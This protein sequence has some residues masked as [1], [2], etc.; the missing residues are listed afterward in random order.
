MFP[1]MWGST[2]LGFGGIGGAAMTSAYTVIVFGC[3]RTDAC[4]YFNG[5]LAYH[6]KAPNKQ[7]YDDMA[8]QS[9][10]QRAGAKLRYSTP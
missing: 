4:V 7:F 5:G 1:Q 6:I 8:A 3:N 9:M 10:V 2:A